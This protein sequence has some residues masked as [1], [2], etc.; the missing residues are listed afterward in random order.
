MAF[1]IDT[2]QG[3]TLIWDCE[4]MKLTASNGE[5]LV[6]DW[7]DGFRDFPANCLGLRQ[8][9][10][11]SDKCRE[12]FD[13]PVSARTNFAPIEFT[14]TIRALCTHTEPVATFTVPAC[15]ENEVR[16]MLDSAGIPRR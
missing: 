9:K 3:L 11:F 6:E 7:F 5:T 13:L 4:D 12:A 2:N 15:D 8:S 1:K 14:K 10:V 16:R